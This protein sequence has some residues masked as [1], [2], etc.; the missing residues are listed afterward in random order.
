MPVPTPDLLGP[1]AGLIGT[2]E[3]DD[4]LDVAF[5]NASRSVIETPYRERVTMNPFGPVENGT[6]SLYGLDYRMAAWR[7]SEEDPFHTEVGYWLWDAAA[8]QVMKCFIVPRGNAVIVGTTTDPDATAFTM[9]AEIG[10]TS[11]GL[12]SNKYLDEAARCTSYEITVTTGPDTWSYDETT[13]VDLAAHSAD[14]T[15]TDRNTLRRVAD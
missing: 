13:V 14:F 15:H 1:L 7:G 3:G 12:L 6:Q 11:Y 5:Q 2:W 4:G 10:S 9:R 8:R